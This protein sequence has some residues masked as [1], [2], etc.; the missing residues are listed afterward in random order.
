M[1]NREIQ[2]MSINNDNI[3]IINTGYLA[4]KKA[5]GNKVIIIFGTKAKTKTKIMNIKITFL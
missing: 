2:K 1:T 5:Q 4:T 3:S